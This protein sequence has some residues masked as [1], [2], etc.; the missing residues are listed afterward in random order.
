MAKQKLVVVGN[1]M[2]GARAVEEVLARG[3]ADMFDIFMFGDEPYGNYNR[4]LLSN[5]LS[6]AQD[7]EEIFLNPLSWY[8]ENGITLHAGARVT[9]IDR[10]AKVVIADN[11][12]REH[13][14]RLLIATGS[15]AFMPP[16]KGLHGA[17]GSL[18]P[19]VFG[20]RTIDDCN[21][22]IAASAPGRKAVVI[23]GGL[24]GLE[25]AR[26]LMNHGCEVHV[27][28]LAGHLMEQQLDFTGG[29]ILKSGMERMGI[30]VHL[31]KSTTE[32]LGEG[33]VTGLAFKD[34]TTLDCD[35][36]VVAAGIRPNAEIGHRAGLTVER[37]IVVDDHMRSVDDRTIY[38]V[39]ECA[40]HRGRVYGLVAPLWDQAKVFAD[41]LTGRNIDAAYHGSKLATKLKVMG[42]ELASMGLTETQEERDELVQ[43]VEPKRG[44][45]KKL[46]VRDGRLVGGILMGD[47]GKAAY[48][49]QA[50]DRD[51]PLPEERLSLLFD[52]GAPSQKVTID[53]MPA[54]AQVCNCNGVTKA[55]IGT[56]IAGGAKTTKAVMGATRAGMGCGSCKG[57][58]NE[59]VAWF[60]GGAVEEDPSVHYYVPCIPLKKPEL[61]AEVRA[62]NLRSVSAVFREL[63]GGVEDAQSKPALA[64]LL[65]VVWRGDYIPEADARFINERAHA[66]IQKDGT[67]SV[68]PPMA[69]GATTPAELRRIAEVA[70][71]YNVPMVKVTG[72]QRI[73][74]L[75]VKKEDLP[76]V[77][78]DLG[79]HSG[80]AYGKTYRTCKSCVGT[81]FC[82]FGLGDSMKL[83]AQIED[84]FK[85]IDSP[86]KMKL[87]TTGCPRNCAEALIKDVGAVAIGDGKWE[88]YVGGAGGSHVRK[89]D[90][91]CTVGSHEEVLLYAGRFMQLYRE[92]AKYK[93]RTY[94]WVERVGIE[95]VRAIVMED[96][97]GI[98]ARLD[99]AMQ[100]SVDAFI[101]PWKQIIEKGM[102]RADA[103]MTA[104]VGSGA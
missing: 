25:A 87:A 38:V 10:Y 51:S 21:G 33:R 16:I 97:E 90:L 58:M 29:T 63:A 71:K 32:I 46:I 49:M 52:I 81:D 41:H 92:E 99:A 55:A 88:I 53:E 98:A 95:R 80:Y 44:I 42:V 72:G 78:A 84:R 45:Y 86:H 103:A 27:V 19:G 70:E 7:T 50:F 60:L 65:S 34:G 75:G 102:D 94:T 1:G 4:I 14:D 57:L 66:N 47:I 36:L 91:L 79:T 20:F 30:A 100:E 83:A 40:Q 73:D 48:L 12:V 2:A 93:E 67:F 5:V 61:V 35:L 15:R 18:K 54:D 56:C 37:A 64:S 8:A 96:S 11:G 82:R 62:R 43:F 69:G 68:V 9:D 76:K 59:V 39:G 24:L 13:Y 3:G 23:G 85:G 104:T 31:Q 28:H 17:D 74:L 26:G 89:G 101:D 77:W 22:M 6:G